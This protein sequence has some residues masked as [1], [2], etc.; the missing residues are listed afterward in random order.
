LLC[1]PACARP[2][3]KSGMPRFGE[4]PRP[5]PKGPG[6][7]AKNQHKDGTGK[8]DGRPAPRGALTGLVGTCLLH[9][10]RITQGSR[11]WL[12]LVQGWGRPKRNTRATVAKAGF[13]LVIDKRGPGR[14]GLFS[15]NMPTKPARTFA[16]PG[17]A[18]LFLLCVCKDENDAFVHGKHHAPRG[19]SPALG[20]VHVPT[21]SHPGTAGFSG[22]TTPPK[23]EGPRFRRD[24]GDRNS[25][26]GA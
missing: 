17:L 24:F 26:P 12:G 18:T 2:D 13:G 21:R 11:G 4:S 7:L 10:K 15:P 9:G 19:S 16:R 22:G 20:Q 3:S 14:D 5:V 6:I 1:S 25:K 8:G 23:V